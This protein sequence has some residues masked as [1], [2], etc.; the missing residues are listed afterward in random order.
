[1][2]V[3]VSVGNVV[4][5]W[6]PQRTIQGLVQCVGAVLE[7]VFVGP[8]SRR[9]NGRVVAVFGFE[10]ATFRPREPRV[11]LQAFEELLIDP[12]SIRET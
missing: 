4:G 7:P 12:V 5:V 11:D 8:S 10:H 1:M 2:A 3:V 6:Q 9:S